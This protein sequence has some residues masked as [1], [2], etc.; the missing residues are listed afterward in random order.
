MNEMIEKEP[1]T[2]PTSR[3]LTPH[4][5]EGRDESDEAFLMGRV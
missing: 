1:K 5:C 4:N 3:S 2:M